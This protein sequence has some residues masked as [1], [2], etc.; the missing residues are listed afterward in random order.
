VVPGKT[1]GRVPADSDETIEDH[2]FLA[3][4][5]SRAFI[6]YLKDNKFSRIFNSVRDE[7]PR[8]GDPEAL[9]TR[10]SSTWTRHSGE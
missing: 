7:T 9:S 2:P 5:D 6:L 3:R 1:A 8:R 4:R 10:F